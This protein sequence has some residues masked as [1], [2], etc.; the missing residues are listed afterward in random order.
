MFSDLLRRDR[1]RAGLSVGQAAWRLGISLAEYRRLEAAE[2]WPDWETF[3]RIERLFGW[4]QTIV[5][6]AQVEGIARSAGS[7]RTFVRPHRSS[8]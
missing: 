4:P 8:P 2:T 1:E 5:G 6:S 7:P 3:D